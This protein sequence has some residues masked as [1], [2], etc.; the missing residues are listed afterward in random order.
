MSAQGNGKFAKAKGKPNKKGEL[1]IKGLTK[2]TTYEVKVV[3]VNK[4]ASS[5]WPPRP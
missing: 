2:N 3:K 4:Q 1:T 5:S